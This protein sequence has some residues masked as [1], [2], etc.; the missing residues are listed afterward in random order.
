MDLAPPPEG[1]TDA[2]D[3]NLIRRVQEWASNHGYAVVIAR[4]KINPKCGSKRKIW[5]RCDRGG[6]ILA[7]HGQKRIHGG[8]RLNE[9]PFSATLQRS[10]TATFVGE[11][12]FQVLKAEHNHVPTPP[13]AHPSLRALAMTPDVI[14]RITAETKSGSKPSEMV[15]RLRY[16]QD[17]ENPLFT[18][19]DVRNQKQAIRLCT[20]GFKSPIQALLQFLQAGDWWIRFL[21]DGDEHITHLFFSKPSA[22]LFIKQFWSVILM[23]CTYKTNKYKMPLLV[24][25]GVTNLNTTYYLAFCLLRQEESDDFRWALEQLRELLLYVDVPDPTCVITDREIS[26]IS[27]LRT[28]FPATKHLLCIWHINKNV[29]SHCKR[30]FTNDEEWDAFTKRWSE[31]VYAPTEADFDAR[32]R[33]IKDDYPVDIWGYPNNTWIMPWKRSFVKCYTDK[34][35]HFGNTSTSRSEGSHAKLKSTLSNSI[36]DLTQVVNGIDKL[37]KRERF[38]YNE[39]INRHKVAPRISHRAPFLRDVFAE[40]P[41]WILEKVLIQHAQIQDNMPACTNTFSKHMG[42][43]CSHRI[44]ERLATPPGLLKVDDFHPHWRYNKAPSYCT[45]H[46]LNDD[47]DDRSE[48][49][50]I[51]PLL[52]VQEPVIG[53]AKGRP[54]GSA[55]TPSQKRTRREEEFDRSTRREPSQFELMEQR[56]QARSLPTSSAS[57]RGRGGQRVQGSRAMSTRGGAQGGARPS[58]A[59]TASQVAQEEEDQEIDAWQ[60]RL[61]EQEQSRAE[62]ISTWTRGS[63]LLSRPPRRRGK[64]GR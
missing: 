57:L 56:L 39:A 60:A 52:R 64:G 5:L 30:L 12:A 34:F 47:D 17:E 10:V 19:K 27:Q 11:W 23:D 38:D 54:L 29:L 40:I 58:L 25:I 59:I 16:D 49:A 8:S 31:L 37:L 61:Q 48:D 36:G 45:R 21:K 44:K 41:P 3:D 46:S 35:L 13:I 55:I 42:I 24:I 28:V 9:C 18:S 62:F 53:R 51:D 33:S 1:M 43:P 20:L 26:C 32:W 7:V 2:S 14:E 6:K 4:S 15:D 63:G 22:H 50:N